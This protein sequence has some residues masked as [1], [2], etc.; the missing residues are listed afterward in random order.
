MANT[1][2]YVDLKIVDADANPEAYEAAKIT[3][4]PTFKFY[5]N[6]AEILTFVPDYIGDVRLQIIKNK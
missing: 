2:S 5:K 4:E 3:R 1:V 6:G